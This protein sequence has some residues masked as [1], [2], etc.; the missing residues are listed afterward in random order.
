M[1]WVELGRGVLEAFA[2]HTPGVCRLRGEAELPFISYGNGSTWG[3]DLPNL[4]DHFFSDPE[5]VRAQCQKDLETK[6]KH[7]LSLPPIPGKRKPRSYR[8]MGNL[9]KKEYMKVYRKEWYERNRLTELARKKE[10]NARPKT[11]EQLEARRAYLK[12]RY[13]NNREK[14]IQQARKRRS[15]ARLS[16]G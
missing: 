1:A 7:A 6:R 12:A 15:A 5:K 4:A 9:G 10:A 14:Y 8:N 13:R 3:K 11:E 16:K 2:E